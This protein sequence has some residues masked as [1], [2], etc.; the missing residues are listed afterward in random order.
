[1]SSSQINNT[2]KKNITNN[3]YQVIDVIQSDVSGDNQNGSS[4]RK[5]ETFV[6][7]SNGVSVTSGL[8]QTIYDQEFSFQT[9]NPVLDMTFGLCYNTGRHNLVS[10]VVTDE[11][12][13]YISTNTEH[14]MLREKVNIYRQYAQNLLGS[15][16]Y[17]FA[18]NSQGYVDMN[19]NA[20]SVDIMDACV[21]IN[22]KRLF[23]RDGIRP[24]TFALRSYKKLQ[25]HS[26]YT[27]F[28]LN[29]IDDTSVGI[30]ADLSTNTLQIRNNEVGILKTADGNLPIGLLFY[31]AGVAVLNMGMSTTPT[32]QNIRDLGTGYSSS[33]G[34][35]FD[36]TDEVFGI[37]NA[38]ESTTGYQL[39]GLD[40]TVEGQIYLGQDGTWN[41]GDTDLPITENATFYPDLLISGSIDNVID[42]IASNRFGSSPLLTALAFQNTT[43]INSSIY[44]CKAEADSYNLSL[45]PTFLD[46][47]NKPRTQINEDSNTA[48]TYITSVLLYD[49]EDDLVA[50]AKL[51]RPIQKTQGNEVNIRVRL[52]F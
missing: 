16:D 40:A 33:Y 15:P 17:A 28:N 25:S 13:G 36:P 38:C 51:N 3:L 5:Y 19:S 45:N 48:Y 35:I 12:E 46:E 2:S 11:A 37:I 20:T 29:S 4:R 6:T 7:S 39:N 10:N 27:Q 31:K 23:H 1:M 21:F 22:I 52:D 41:A 14:L 47:N 44:F 49:D 24:E 43:T 42:H 50:V 30:I 18:L 26:S 8:Y 9:S 34:V 32:D